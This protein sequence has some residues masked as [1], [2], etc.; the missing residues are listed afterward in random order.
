MRATVGSAAPGAVAPDYRHTRKPQPQYE[1][2]STDSPGIASESQLRR[3]EQQESL[4]AHAPA[5][6][7]LNAV[8]LGSLLW[9]LIFAAAF[10]VFG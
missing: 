4:P 7:V 10:W 5:Q 3:I 9:G 2:L 8:L 1:L 6:G